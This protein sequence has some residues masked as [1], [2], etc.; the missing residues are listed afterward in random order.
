M[1]K[2]RILFLILILSLLLSTT[3]NAEEVSDEI[4]NSISDDFNTFKDSLPEYAKDF[5]PNELFEGDFTALLNG[6]IDEK[7]F[8]D[9]TLS[10]LSSGINTVLKGFASVLAL[11]IIISIFNTLSTSLSETNVN[12]TFSVCSTLCIAITVFNVCNTLASNASS[13]MKLLCN[14]MNSFIPIM[15]SLL[16]M[17]GNMSSAVVINSSVILFIGVV[18]GFL[19][20]FMLPLIKM[21]L[22]FGCVKSFGSYCDVG[23]ISKTV[24]TTFTSVTVFVMSLF[25]FVLSYK[26]TL[27]QSADSISL[28]TARFAISSFVPLVG[29]SVNDALKTVSA[30]LSLIKK[31]CGIIAIIAI[32]V[33]MLPIIINLLLN[34]LSFNLLSSLSKL[35]NCNNESAVLE[36]ADSVCGFLLTLVCCTCILFIFSLTI[37]LKSGIEV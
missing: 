27:S 29:A 34:K 10:Y 12:S 11:I 30:S 16:T 28:K 17:S 19:L 8:L 36:E 25:M 24:K 14:V 3:I 7:S 31:S 6:S 21:C 37:F 4:I 33:I 2:I 18:E 15:I 13:Y 32:A 1:K 35:L 20:A 22:A 5:F 26:S 9:L 23:G